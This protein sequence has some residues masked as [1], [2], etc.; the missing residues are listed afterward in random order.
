MTN[1]NDNHNNNH[2]QLPS[3]AAGSA[4][5]R[6]KK[7]QRGACVTMICGGIDIMP[8]HQAQNQYHHQPPT[9]HTHTYA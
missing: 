4:E 2:N 8:S 7:R 9:H 5:E 1:D 3:H 6:R